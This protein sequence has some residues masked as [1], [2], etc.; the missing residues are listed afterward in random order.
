MPGYKG[1]TPLWRAGKKARSQQQLVWVAGQLPPAD[2]L[3]RDFSKSL[4]E[5]EPRKLSFGSQKGSEPD[6]RQTSDIG[7]IEEPVWA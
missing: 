7:S 6:G 2:V 1:A 4:P 3:K 5:L